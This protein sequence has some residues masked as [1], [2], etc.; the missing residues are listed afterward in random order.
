MN[1][2]LAK[3]NLRIEKILSA[4]VLKTLLSL[5]APLIIAFF[6]NSLFQLIDMLY[7]AK[8]GSRHIAAMSINIIPGYFMYAIFIGPSIGIT[9]VISRYIGADKIKEAKNIADHG[10]SLC[11]IISIIITTLGI[12]FGRHILYLLGG[13]GKVL[14]LAW[15]Y[16]RIRLISFFFMG[17]RLILTGVLRGE[18][19]MKTSMNVLIAATITNIIL[20]P[21][22]IFG[23][24][25]IPS[26]GIEGAAIATAIA[27]FAGALWILAV[28][29]KKNNIININF[30]YFKFKFIYYKEI[31]KIGLPVIVQHLTSIIAMSLISRLISGYGH[32][33]LASMGIG[34]RLEMLAIIPILA[35][36]SAM[37][38]MVGQNYGAKNYKRVQ[39]VFF[40]GILL[41][42]AAALF[43]GSILFS[44]PSFF[45]KM[46]RNDPQLIKTAKLFL[47]ILAGVLIF[48]GIGIA[49]SHFFQGIGKGIIALSLTF[50][51]VGILTVPLSY[52]FSLN[53]GLKGIWYA[54]GLSVILTSLIAGVFSTYYFKVKILKKNKT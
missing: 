25:F 51:R 45:I 36:S 37:L 9:S 2:K 24:Y 6:L 28:F 1:N 13:T 17:F 35:I 41:N 49:H 53:Y 39:K 11:I 12:I 15:K 43:L 54:I 31:Y 46:F 44:A 8:L 4:P 50:I 52:M 21:I 30:K 48:S 19:N 14:T 10:V 20:D 5:S 38:T 42:A 7:V 16:L 18:G 34:V 3:N 32:Y 33:A 27:N 40:S 29:L 26:F 23:F 22:L 47:K